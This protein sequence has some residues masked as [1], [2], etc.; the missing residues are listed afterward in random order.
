LVLQLTLLKFRQAGRHAELLRGPTVDVD[1]EEYQRARKARCQLVELL[2]M[3]RAQ[4]EAMVEARLG[5]KGEAVV[6]EFVAGLTKS[7]AY[8]EIANIPMMLSMLIA[9]FKS[10]G[11]AFP[12]NRSELYKQAVDAVMHSAH[13]VLKGIKG[14][15]DQ[16]PRGLMAAGLGLHLLSRHLQTQGL[17]RAFHRPPPAVLR[18]LIWCCFVAPLGMLGPCAG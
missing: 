10:R 6:Q 9:V 12:K 5:E 2:P 1:S 3:S 11:N 7:S 14:G 8:A 4:Q 17:S 13:Q 16:P 18:Q 15:W